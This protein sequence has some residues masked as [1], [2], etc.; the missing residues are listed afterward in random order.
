MTKR[1][2]IDAIQ[3]LNATADAGFLARFEE[4][5]LEAYLGKLH[6]ARSPR[7]TGDAG[8]Y[9]KYFQSAS[10]PAAAAE[11]T[12]SAAAVAMESPCLP[13][14]EEDESFPTFYREEDVEEDLHD[15]IRQRVERFAEQL[16][17]T[18][19]DD[20][21]DESEDIED[22]DDVD[23]AAEAEEDEETLAAEADQPEEQDEEQVEE[24]LQP[25]AETSSG[26]DQDGDSWLF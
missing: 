4:D 16:I 12:A 18:N 9:E 21:Y 23:L 13:D 26:T 7:L 15:D 8:R 22:E 5:D 20:T 11:A 1:E 2:L 3:A 14:E 6:W 19:M 17:Q 10:A 25:V 24:E